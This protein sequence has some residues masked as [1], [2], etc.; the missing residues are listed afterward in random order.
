[1]FA[2]SIMKQAIAVFLLI[3]VNINAK[4]ACTVK[5]INNVRTGPSSEEQIVKK[6]PIYTP[7][8]L[9]EEK[10]EWAKVK[11][12]DFQGWIYTSLID[13]KTDC[14][15]IL[16]TKKPYCFKQKEKLNRPISFNEGFKIIKKDVGCNLV[17]GKWGKQI[18]L[19]SNNIWAASAAKLLQI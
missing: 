7:L 13:K 3:I 11:G 8:I 17:E 4:D 2:E 10:E 5:Q 16:N 14:M 19:N 6:I 9:L 12:V 1:M 18:W 15:V